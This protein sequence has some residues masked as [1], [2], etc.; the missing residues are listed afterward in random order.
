MVR[1][2]LG[3]VVLRRMTLDDIESVKALIKEGCEGTENRLVL[4]LLTRPLALFLLAVLSS[5]LRCLIHS[6]VLALVIPVFLAVIYLKLTMPRS[7]GILGAHRRYWDYVGSTYKA[8]TD[9][10][11]VNPYSRM[12]KPVVVTKA[13]PQETKT[14]KRK[15]KKGEKDKGKEKEK[16][17]E[18]HDME[19][20]EDRARVAGEVWVADSEG[21]VIGCLSREPVN[22]AGVTRVCRLV[23]SSWY[24]REGVASLLVQC[25]AH[26]EKGR[27]SRRV[28]AHVPFPSRVGE[29][30]FRKLGYRLQGE[31]ADGEEVDEDDDYEDPQRGWLG[32]PITKVFVKD[33]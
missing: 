12:A 18:K 25:L 15:K 27:G 6:F 22:R 3:N 26:R 2:D 31:V 11:L 19:D 13:K 24:R 4:H 14:G 7:T 9:S 8:E 23:V 20:L 28:Y 29:A 33:M 21:E 10:E 30:F 17:K 5:I 32:Y 1:L 16:E